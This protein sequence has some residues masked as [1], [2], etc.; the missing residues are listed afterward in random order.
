MLKKAFI[1]VLVH[2]AVWT[3]LILVVPGKDRLD[4]DLLG[5][6]A[7]PWVRQ[8]IVALLAVLALQIVFITREKMWADVVRDRP[9]STRQWMWVPSLLIAA[10]GIAAVVGSGISGAPR[11]YWIGMSITMLLVGLTE[12]VTFR[13]ILIVGVRRTGGGETKALLVSS[14]L[15]GLFHLPNGLLGQAWNTTIRQVIVTGVIGVA[16]YALRRASGTLLACIVLHAA[17]DWAVIQ[18]SFA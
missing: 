15:F 14:V 2:T 8:F 10:V 13:G 7:T 6:A 16:F 18:G 11:S 12:E 1:F 3:S 9:R 4:Y 17:Y 5:D